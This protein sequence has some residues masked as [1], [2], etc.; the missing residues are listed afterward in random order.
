MTFALILLICIIC[1]TVCHLV[2]KDY[3]LRPVF[4]GMLGLLFG[5]LAIPFVY[6]AGRRNRHRT[7]PQH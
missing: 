7:F 3:G 1:A 4:W 2:A 6:L 5:P